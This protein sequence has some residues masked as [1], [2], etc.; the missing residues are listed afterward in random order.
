MMCIRE[1]NEKWALCLTVT[2]ACCSNAVK[3]D[4]Q[5]LP[6]SQGEYVDLIIITSRF[7]VVY[8]YLSAN[9]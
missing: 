3:V 8:V 7:A 2:D 6:N 9:L 4:G 1:H 5:F